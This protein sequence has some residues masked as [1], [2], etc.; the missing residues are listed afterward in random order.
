[1]EIKEAG[2]ELLD[3]FFSSGVSCGIKNEGLDL[4]VIYA[5]CDTNAAAVFTSNSIKAAPVRLSKLTLSKNKNI[6]AIVVNSGNA[7]ACTGKIGMEHAK[8][9]QR[10]TAKALN[11]AK[12]QVLVASTGVI[13]RVMPIDNVILGITRAKEA[14]H[15]NSGFSKAIMTTDRVEKKLSIHARDENGKDFTIAAVMKGS[16]MIAPK[17]EATMLCFVLTDYSL[18]QDALQRYLISAVDKSFNIAIVDGDMST[19]DTVFLLAPASNKEV[20]SSA[21]FSLALTTLL[22][23]MAKR[24]VRDGEGATKLFEVKVIRA[25]SESKARSIARA[26]VRS[27]L[28]KSAVFGNDPNWGRIISAA[29]SVADIDEEKIRVTFSDGKNNVVMYP[30]KNKEEKVKSI[31]SLD[32]F[33]IIFDLGEGECTSEAFG[34]DLTYDYVKINAK[35]TT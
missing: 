26:I 19:N 10:E 22:I 3:D 8:T 2:F 27:P 15:S 12:D 24:M 25:M 30:I 29:G 11:I 18:S 31:M 9:M 35:Y 1:M 16:G 17:L 5:K 20:E 23:E 28:V 7:N 32:Y 4:G 34:C 21:Q 13:G 6:R 14:L 33:Q